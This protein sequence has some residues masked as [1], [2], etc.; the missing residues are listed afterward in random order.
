MRKSTLP[1]SNYNVIKL[2]SEKLSDFRGDSYLSYRKAFTSLQLF[3]I[4]N[5]QADEPFNK[6][7]VGNWLI[8][9]I[10]NG[11]AYNTVGFYLD[12]VSSLYGHIGHKLEGGKRDLFKEVKKKF[13]GL[14]KKA[15]SVDQIKKTAVRIHEKAVESKMKKEKN[16]LVE[17]VLGMTDDS[18]NSSTRLRRIWG[19]VALD[20][21]VMGDIVKSLVAIPE[22]SDCFLSLVES[23]E[24]EKINRAEI[25]KKIELALRGEAM[26]WYAMRLRPRVKYETLLERFSLISK[27]FKI[28][29]LF[30]PSE[31][32]AKKIGHKVV[33]S[34]RPV[35]RDIVFFKQRHSEIFPML[36]KIYDIAWCYKK[37]GSGMSRYASIP[38]NAMEEFRRSLGIL[39]PDF[40][41]A[42]AGEMELRPGDEVIVV[43]GEHVNEKG[44]ILKKPNYDEDG[45]K[46][47][48]VALLKDSG[49]WDVG[50][51]ARLL[52]KV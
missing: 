5:F 46:I 33:W 51:D 26:E 17:A 30:Y 16:I 9:N 34:G 2:M 3:L 10:L 38:G 14:D 20:A 23:R 27:D 47:F 32:I 25:S 19:C 50:I 24:K 49:A 1:A 31:E 40:E 39:S 36:T 4:T 13:R 6:N 45:H 12:K 22:Q 43:T 15:L 29:E 21:G 52:K 8:S 11:L 37:P 35:I 7:V 42:P 41:V 28:P 18:E 44:T 48:R